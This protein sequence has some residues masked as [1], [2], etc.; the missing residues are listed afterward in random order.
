[1]TFDEIDARYRAAVLTAEAGGEE[2]DDPETENEEED[3]PEEG[4]DA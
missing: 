1:M 4:E 2:W 3:E